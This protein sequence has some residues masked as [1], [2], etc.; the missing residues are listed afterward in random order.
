[1]LYKYK[2]IL[3]ISVKI[4]NMFKANNIYKFINKR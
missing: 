1:M 4:K 2:N 3:P